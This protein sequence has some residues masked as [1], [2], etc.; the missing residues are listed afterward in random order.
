MSRAYPIANKCRHEADHAIDER[1]R[2]PH[3]DPAPV[4]PAIPGADVTQHIAGAASEWQADAIVI[5]T[6]GRRG[7][8]RFVLGSVAERVLR[9]ALCPV[10]MILGRASGPPQPRLSRLPPKRN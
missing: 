5:G 7:L 9:D 1:Q 10:L 3:F 6:H 8:R 4:E 2:E